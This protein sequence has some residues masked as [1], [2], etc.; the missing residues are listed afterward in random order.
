MNAGCAIWYLIAG[1]ALAGCGSQQATAPQYPAEPIS[2]SRIAFLG[3]SITAR[4]QPLPISGAL[5]FGVSGETSEQIAARMPQVISAGAGVIII[6]AGTNDIL[7]S[8]SANIDYV[9][10]MA[11]QARDAGARVLLCTIPPTTEGE[12]DSMARV[13]AFNTSLTEWAKEQGFDLVDYYDALAPDY[14]GDTVDGIHPDPAGYA[15]MAHAL[16]T[17]L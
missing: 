11:M 14:P 15:L 6:L 9:E 10:S 7:K 5:N 16:E 3:D 2:P 4:W 12:G 8:A 17:I 1:A 13:Q